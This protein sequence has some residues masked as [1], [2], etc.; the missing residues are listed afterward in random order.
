MTRQLRD[1][2]ELNAHLMQMPIGLESDLNG[3]IDLITMKAIYFDGA[4]GDDI[5]IEE[6]PAAHAGRSPKEA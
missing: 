1:K 2:L 4:S 5:R 3:V 6:I